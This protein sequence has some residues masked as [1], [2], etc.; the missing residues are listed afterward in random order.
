MRIARGQLIS[1]RGPRHPGPRGT[2]LF[3]LLHAPPRGVGRTARRR[4][5]GDGLLRG[6]VNAVRVRALLNQ[7]GLF[8]T[9]AETRLMSATQ[10]WVPATRFSLGCHMTII[11]IITIIVIIIVIAIALAIAIITIIAIIIITIIV[12][13]TWPFCSNRFISITIKQVHIHI[14]CLSVDGHSAYLSREGSRRFRFSKE[15]WP[16]VAREECVAQSVFHST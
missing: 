1:H 10:L 3:C 12:A 5:L 15:W 8:E 4:R 13:G 6:C 11:I 9:D 16:E 7:V 14:I 2:E